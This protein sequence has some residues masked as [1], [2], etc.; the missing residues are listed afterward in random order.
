MPADTKPEPKTED[1]DKVAAPTMEAAPT[2]VAKAPEPA[3]Q[4]PADP[5]PAPGFVRCRVTKFGH[6]K[7][8]TGETRQNSSGGYDSAPGADDEGRSV[9]V[10]LFPRHPVNTIVD[11]PLRAAQKYEARGD[12]EI[13]D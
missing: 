2:E 5:G 11:L 10:D 12:V 13:Q 8:Y 6:D 7:I 4:P 9:G 1:T 3:A